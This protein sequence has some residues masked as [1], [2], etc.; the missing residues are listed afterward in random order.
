MKDGSMLAGGYAPTKHTVK[1]TVKTDVQNI[2]AFR[3][4]LL[5][6]PNLPRGGPGRS[7]IGT[8]VLTEFK[9]EAAP[10]SD[11]TQKTVVKIVKATADVNQPE[12]P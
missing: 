4:E 3:L 2:R 7:T 6:D 1:F 10:A 9:V 12:R 11:P 5:K 8:G